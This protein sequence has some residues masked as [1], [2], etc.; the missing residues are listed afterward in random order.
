LYGG[1]RLFAA[2]FVWPRSRKQIG[3]LA[4]LCS[5]DNQVGEIEPS[6]LPGAIADDEAGFH[7]PIPKT[8]SGL[9]VASARVI[10][11]LVSDRNRSGK[12]QQVRTFL[13]NT[14]K[15]PQRLTVILHAALRCGR[16]EQ[17]PR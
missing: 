13:R 15:Y 10:F 9:D 14:S 8:L 6:G 11:H 2:R 12:S 3:S 16:R 17:L 4:F 1:L 7:R 5:I